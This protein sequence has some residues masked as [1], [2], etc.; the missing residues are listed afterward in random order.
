[1]F[2]SLSSKKKSEKTDKSDKTETAVGKVTEDEPTFQS[3]VIDKLI[4]Q[5]VLDTLFVD[6]SKSLWH[7]FNSLAH[8]RVVQKSRLK[9]K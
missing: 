1:M 3:R 7:A 2:R 9:V 5:Q 8:D 4:S 6:F